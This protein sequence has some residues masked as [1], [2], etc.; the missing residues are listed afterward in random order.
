MMKALALAVSVVFAPP[1]DTTIETAVKNGLR[2]LQGIGV[3]KDHPRALAWFYVA[4]SID[5]SVGSYIGMVEPYL[6]DEQL[7]RARAIADACLK[8]RIEYCELRAEGSDRT[9]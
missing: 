5:P 1:P 6:S 4:R 9:Q 7:A 8:V 3:A 2:Y